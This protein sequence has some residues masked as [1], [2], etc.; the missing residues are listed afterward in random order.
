MPTPMSKRND[1]SLW[2]ARANG[3]TRSRQWIETFD[4]TSDKVATRLLE[5]GRIAASV[6]ERRMLDQ[7]FV[8]DAVRGD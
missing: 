8:R 5:R 6:L 7:R 4:A 3:R 2:C 1:E